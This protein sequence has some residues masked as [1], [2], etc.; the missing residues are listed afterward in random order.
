M[1]GKKIL[2]LLFVSTMFF[3]AGC[4]PKDETSTQTAISST[5]EVS[6]EPTIEYWTVNFGQ[7]DGF[8]D[9]RM[10]ED[11]ELKNEILNN[12]V[13]KGEQ[14]VFTFSLLDPTNTEIDSV[15][16]RVLSNPEGTP[17]TFVRKDEE[18]FVY[19]ISSVND[20]IVVSISA[21]NID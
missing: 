16:Y 3:L 14:V 11:D 1:I 8:K 5:V 4:E 20:D 9:L 19:K 18:T 10:Y 12:K 7:S 2:P 15:T 6:I 17:A 13:V 21:K